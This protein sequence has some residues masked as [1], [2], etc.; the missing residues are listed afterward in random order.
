MPLPFESSLAAALLAGLA[1]CAAAPAPALA[2][3]TTDGCSLFPN[4]API[5]AADWCGCCVAHD[6]AYW[7]GG[8]EDERLAADRELER[9]VTDAV[10]EPALATA[11]FAGVRAGGSPYFVTPYRWAYGWPYGRGYQPLD[12]RERAQAA[13]LQAEYLAGAAAPMC[14]APAR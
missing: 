2:P 6:L 7:R 1:G 10:H 11:M 13:T 12:A 14:P 8:T 4:R 3:F 9:C 5:G